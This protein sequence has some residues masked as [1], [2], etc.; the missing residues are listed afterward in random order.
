MLTGALQPRSAMSLPTIGP[1]GW[2]SRRE[3]PAPLPTSPSPGPGRKRRLGPVRCPGE[4]RRSPLAAAALRARAS[5]W[6]A[7]SGASSCSSA[8]PRAGSFPGGFSRD[9]PVSVTGHLPAGNGEPGAVERGRDVLGH[10]GGDEDLLGAGDHLG[11]SLPAADVE[12]G[13]DVVQDEDGSVVVVLGEDRVG[14]EPERQRVGPRLA[15]ARVALGGQPAEGEDDVVAVGPDEAHAALDLPAAQLGH[16]RHE[17]LLDG[18]G[19]GECGLLL[20][21]RLAVTVAVDGEECR[22]VAEPGLTLAAA[23]LLVGPRDVRSQ[24]AHQL[25]AGG[26][27]LG[28]G[29]REVAVPDVEGREVGRRAPAAAG[30]AGGL[31]QRPALAQDL[32]VLAAHPGQAG[33]QEDE[34]VVEEAAAGL[35]VPPDELEVLGGEDDAAQDAEDDRKST[36][37]NSSHVAITYAVFRLTQKTDDD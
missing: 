12:L 11:Q 21:A 29:C 15:V 28:A 1:S 23:D 9:A 24:L 10:R 7:A 13:E 25:N 5:A 27:D 18:R 16:R 31:Q 19:V 17:P 33:G 26:D 30:R 22:A 35:R 37:R 3:G 6:R 20:L 32:V 14:G 36:R 4:V 8:S 2:G 34:Q